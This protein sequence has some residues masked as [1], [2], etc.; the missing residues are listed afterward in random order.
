MAPELWNTLTGR[1]GL[2]LDA[3]QYALLHAFLDLLFSANQRMNLTRITDRAQAEILHIADS[4]TL[5][6]HLPSVPHRLADVG[7]GGGLPGIVLAI[8]RPDA[9]VVLIESTKK[10]GDFL[11]AAATE[12]KLANVTVAPLRAEEMARSPQTKPFDVAVA[13]AVAPLGI[14]IPWL[15]PLVRPGGWALAM[16]GPKVLAELDQAQQAAR[17]AGGGPSTIVA[18]DLPDRPGH[19]IVKIPKDRP[20]G[21]RRTRTASRA[22]DKSI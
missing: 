4:L 14:L 17:R 2:T 15:L 22:G 10:K 12:L 18:A 20:P 9:Q 5:L 6:P 19:L 7:S 8:A 11:I 1:A 3:R 13:R 16:K 21:G